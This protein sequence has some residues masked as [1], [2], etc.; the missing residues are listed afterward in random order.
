MSWYRSYKHDVCTINLNHRIESKF[1][2]I[3]L[4]SHVL[5][6]MPCNITAIGSCNAL[7]MPFFSF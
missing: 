1:I 4:S 6:N 3:S 2:N 7:H 5:Q